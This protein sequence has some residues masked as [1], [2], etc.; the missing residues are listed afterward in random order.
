MTLNYKEAQILHAHVNFQQGSQPSE[1]GKFIIDEKFKSS[2][3]NY[4]WTQSLNQN[5]LYSLITIAKKSFIGSLNNS[6]FLSI[7]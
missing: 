6:C 4:V 1:K 2:L 7:V 5:E 3:L